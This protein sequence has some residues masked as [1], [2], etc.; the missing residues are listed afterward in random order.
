[1]IIYLEKKSTFRADVSSNRIEEK[2][3]DTLKAKAGKSVGE[4]ELNSWKNSLRYMDAIVEDPKIPDDTGIAIEFN[5]P[6][7][8]KRIDFILTGKNG[9]GTRTAVIVELKQ[10]QRVQVTEK[11]AIVNTFI[12][13][14]DRDTS[15]PSYQAWSYASLIEDYNETV[16]NE[17]IHLQPCAYLKLFLGH[18]L[19]MAVEGHLNS[20]HFMGVHK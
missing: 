16:R 9:D 19:F 4:S 17:P 2:V 14:S 13:R 7:T 6:N 5:V 15:H 11:D 8:S 10:W 1:M 20:L 12:G 3:R 18:P